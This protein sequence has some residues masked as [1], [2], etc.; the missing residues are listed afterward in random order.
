MSAPLYDA[1][2]IG[3]GPA[4]CSA[5]IT[6]AGQGARVVMF[7]AKTY[8]HDKLCGEFL[9]PE[10]GLL[11]ANL[12]LVAEL[13]A[14]EP[15]SIRT[16]RL[17]AGGV[18]WEAPLP[19]T[20]LGLTRAALD[21]ALADRA[22]QVGVE[23]REG[24]TV[25]GI[26]GGLAEGFTL[27][28]RADGR[29]DSVRACTVIAAHGKR[30][31]LDH[32]LGR[33]FAAERHPFVGLKAHHRGPA[34][35]NRIELHAFPGGYCGFSEIEGGLANVCL[36]VREEVLRAHAGGAGHLEGFVEWMA[37]QN[38]HLGAWLG[39]A[40]RVDERWLSIGQVAFTAKAPA[41]SDVLMAGDAAGLIAPLAGDGI[42]MALRGGQLAAQYVTGYLAGQVSAAALPRRYA[43]AWSREFRPR[44]HLA[45]ALQTLMLRPGAASA[46]LRVISAAP[47][48]GDWLIRRTRQVPADYTG[49]GTREQTWEIRRS[50]R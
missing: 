14:L 19:G 42:A 43:A 45:R 41:V 11:L 39:A 7:E 2:V 30:S 17:T 26:G 27:A 23:V 1:A 36:L 9:S 15:V 10:C 24:T 8:P 6:L 18:S 48:L 22:R 29:R 49:T 21:A 46:A 44:L 13:L 40:E 4:G 16:S 37:G 25:T 32:A 34:L 31:R 28:A 50:S 33:P 35:P 20:A 5:A 12:G 3:G 38:P 47:V